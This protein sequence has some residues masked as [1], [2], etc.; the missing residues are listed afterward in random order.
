MFLEA[1][2]L[3]DSEF[4]ESTDREITK[5]ESEI[6]KLKKEIASAESRIS[7]LEKENENLVQT[8]SSLVSQNQKLKNFKESLKK[9]LYSSE[10]ISR[11]PAKFS[12]FSPNSDSVDGK[13]FFKDARSRLSYETFAV[14][15]NYVKRLNDKTIT[16]EKALVELEAV[17]G[18]ENSDL[19][20]DFSS[21]LLRK[22]TD[23]NF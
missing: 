14:F 17:F 12:V 8:F 13:N 4:S 6:F 9:S 2:E 21:L 10:N 20:E 11:I 18:P 22:S 23:Y 3:K 15:L 7:V 16:K 1:W 5:T 19:H